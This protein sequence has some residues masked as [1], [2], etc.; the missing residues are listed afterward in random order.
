MLVLSHAAG[1]L[2]EKLITLTDPL[3]GLARFRTHQE[4]L[5]LVHSVLLKRCHGIDRISVAIFDKQTDRLKT[6]VSSPP[7]ESPLR[8][9][10]ASLNGSR[11][12]QECYR[13]GRPR[14]VHDMEVFSKGRRDHTR[15]LSGHGFSSSYTLP[16]FSQGA[17]EGFVF[18][19]S[20]HKGYF[21]ELVLEQVEI[22]SHLIAQ[23]IINDISAMRA[24][25]AALRT[26]ISMV[27]R[28]DPETGNH[29]ER[30]AR[31]SLLIAREMVDR[32]QCTF[33]DEQIT[34]LFNFS[35]LH[36]VGK[37]GIPDDILLKPSRLSSAERDVMITHTT[38]GR[39]IVDDLISN[40]GFEKLPYIDF[41]RQIAE[42]HHE[43]MDGSGYPHGLRGGDIP[44]EARIIAVSD[45][46]DALTSQRSYKEPWTNSHA[47][48]M[49]QL[50]SIDKLDANC[51]AALANRVDDVVDIQQ[52]FR[53]VA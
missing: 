5:E 50:L 40:F 26:S 25:V 8:N 30:M 14:V 38:I 45:V 49:L 22:Y 31:F 19:N 6:F 32:E 46:F 13:T 52:Q 48:A 37:I 15:L 47:F 16:M 34:Q 39:Q 44:L 43:A 3:A 24:L 51:V 10:E 41:L 53:D 11:S 9:Y 2:L 7:E 28:K 12:L 4:K 42:H 21:K 17:L 35:P 27:H 23:M 29:L 20:V 33:D 18:L 36:D 1:V